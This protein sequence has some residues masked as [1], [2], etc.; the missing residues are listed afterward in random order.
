ME[1][2]MIML[3]RSS[4]NLP[5]PDRSVS[6][7]S[8][9]CQ[10]LAVRRGISIVRNHY[11]ATTNEDY[12]RVSTLSVCCSDTDFTASYFRRY[13]SL[14]SLP[15]EP[16]IAQKVTQTVTSAES[17]ILRWET[18]LLSKI[19]LNIQ[20]FSSALLHIKLWHTLKDVLHRHILSISAT[21]SSSQNWTRNILW[22]VNPLLDY[23]NGAWLGCRPLS[24]SRP[25]TRCAAVGD[26][27]SSQPSRDDVTRQHARF[28]GNAVV[29]TVT[30]RNSVDW[31]R[32]SFSWFWLYKRSG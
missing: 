17:W 25:S 18:K 13:N 21:S 6:V 27:G 14:E 20:D 32:F 24:A 11:L 19:S 22:H 4:R 16:Q 3:V 8:T 28:R 23:A 12:N 9:H 1:P 2:V 15:W 7:V 30:W 5:E 10:L 31:L 29:N 26:A